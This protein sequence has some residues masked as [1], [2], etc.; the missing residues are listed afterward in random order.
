MKKI[1]F[2]ESSHDNF[3]GAQQSLYYFLVNTDCDFQKTVVL[4]GIGVFY[5]KLVQENIHTEI[6]EYPKSFQSSGA[7]I[8][9]SGLAVK[10]RV[11]VDAMR[12]VRGLLKYLKE[13]DFDVVY[14]NDIRTIL[15]AGLAGR[16]LGIPVVWYVRGCENRSLLN[17][18]AAFLC[19]KIVVIAEG[20]KSSFRKPV[21]TMRD[22][23]FVTVYSGI[24]IEAVDEIHVDES[25]YAELGITKDSIVI[26][27][28][29]NLNPK[30]GQKDLL[31]ALLKLKDSLYFDNIVILF[32]GHVISKHNRVY[33]EDLRE[34][35]QT[36]DLEEMVRFLG[37]RDDGIQIVKM[38]RFVVSPSYS[39]GLPR[40]VLEAM[41]CSKAVV[42]T[43]VGGTRELI[44]QTNGILINC[45]DV[46]GLAQAIDQ[47]CKNDNLALEMGKQGRE[48]V[49]TSFAIQ[50][51]TSSLGCVLEEL[52]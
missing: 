45:G 11:V 52:L 29:A 36:N 24:D 48:K 22:S 12:Y 49:E 31:R 30:K 6:V 15:T 38:S 16:M 43:D 42:A 23:V 1:V 40:S 35:V 39:E 13:N 32:V 20:I 5:D 51:Y 10:L 25:L 50:H 3:Y 19:T 34:F 46:S 37:W 26:S 9:K 14:C 41:A 18:L 47:L 4:P 8:K 28:V 33:E 17:T 2:F 44:D 27:H 21:V 7:I